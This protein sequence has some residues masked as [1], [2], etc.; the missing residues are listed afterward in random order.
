MKRMMLIVILII[1]NS[2]ADSCAPDDGFCYQLELSSVKNFSVAGN[3][4]LVAGD[5]I[6]AN[7]FAILL[8]GSGMGE[9]CLRDYSF[10]GSLMADLYYEST[11]KLIDISIGSIA[12][13]GKSYPAGSELKTLFFPVSASPDCLENNLGNSACVYD[14]ME[15]SS[16]S[17]LE[18]ALNGQMGENILI[19]S[20][21][22]VKNYLHLF[23]LKTTENISL[24][25]HV[26]TLKFEFESGKVIEFSTEKIILI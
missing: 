8:D 23:L 15:E 5:T 22:E 4:E 18:E 14:Y 17:T 6:T 24:N 16:I 2:L 10:G 21:A 20:D 19:D 26:F 12:D 7:D 9:Y 3:R 13:L 25:S 1:L 11:D